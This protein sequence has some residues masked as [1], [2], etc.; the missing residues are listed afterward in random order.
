MDNERLTWEQIKEK[1]PNQ[2]V[3]LEEVETNED[4]TYIKSAVV[5]DADL[6]DKYDCYVIHNLNGGIYLM[7]TALDGKIIE[8]TPDFPEV[9]TQFGFGYIGWKEN[10]EEVRIEF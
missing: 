4:K 6:K 7:N 3:W 9:P 2:T 8:D 10:G 5:K 1:Y